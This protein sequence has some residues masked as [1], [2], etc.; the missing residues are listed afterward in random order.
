VIVVSG[1]ST[2]DGEL[3]VITEEKLGS[4]KAC[5]FPITDHSC[6]LRASSPDIVQRHNFYCPDLFTRVTWKKKRGKR[7]VV[8]P[9]RGIEKGGHSI[10]SVELIL[11]YVI[12]QLH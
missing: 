7:G 9:E 11:G 3:W 10:S 2:M 5:D 1:E 8:G 12:V 4:E 6:R